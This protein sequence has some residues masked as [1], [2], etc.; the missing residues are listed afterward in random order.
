MMR[1]FGQLLS[2]Y[3]ARTG[4]SDSELARALGVR[5]QTIFRWKEGMTERPRRREGVLGC[6]A[7]LRLSPEE[8]D[9]LLLAAGFAPEQVGRRGPGAGG[10]EEDASGR[11]G[12]AAD[13]GR[14]AGE[15]G[16]SGADG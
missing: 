14:G 13:E 4:V 6:A 8:R 1:S 15:G 3:T 11:A 9:E 10:V 5:R 2:E 7:K 16:P 12:E